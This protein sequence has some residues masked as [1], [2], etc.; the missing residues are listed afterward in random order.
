MRK[1]LLLAVLAALICAAP[2]RAD[3]LVYAQNG[4]IYLAYPEGTQQTRLTKDEPLYGSVSVADDGTIASVWGGGSTQDTFWFRT[5]DRTGKMLTNTKTPRANTNFSGVY[6]ARVSPDGTKIAFDMTYRH[7]RNEPGCPLTPTECENGTWATFTAVAEVGKE[8]P[9]KQ[10]AFIRDW[11]QPT[12]IDNN[13]LLVSRGSTSQMGIAT[14]GGNPT[15]TANPWAIEPGTPF[16]GGEVNRQGT[17]AAFG[18]D[19]G[20]RITIW[21]LANGAGSTPTFCFQLQEPNISFNE[22]S[23]SPDGNGL[24]WREHDGIY[25]YVGGCDAKGPLNKVIA[26]PDAYDVYWGPGDIPGKERPKPQPTPTP[27]PTPT[28]VPTPAPKP[29]PAAPTLAAAGK[30]PK[31]KKLGKS[32]GLRVTCDGA[33][34]LSVT[35][36]IAK[37]LAKRL[38]IKPTIAKGRATGSATLKLALSK[39]VAKKLAKQKRVT[40][41][42]KASGTNSVGAP[43]SAATTL[44]LKR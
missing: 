11:T 34:S 41:S 27:T 3:S 5:F 26:D 7:D 18:T 22:L 28:P 14:L 12:W 33:C 40:V 2:A 8:T 16:Y 44:V 29:Q 10:I 13:R 37:S 25:T 19:N 6:W 9:L 1:G 30:L 32:L 20:K 43:V 39:K 24:A 38:K 36:T 35:A 31:L 42:V 21:N 23:W 17:R 4:D 15:T